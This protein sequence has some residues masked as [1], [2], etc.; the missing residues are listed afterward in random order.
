ML[1]ED[2]T[3]FSQAILEE[4]KQEA[5]EIV[6]R[7]RR[8]AER[9]F[10]GAR[11]ELDQIYLA[12][13][14]HAKKQQAQTRYN[15]IISAAELEV[16]RQKL[17]AQERLIA[18]VQEQVKER[19]LQARNDPRYPDILVSLIRRGIAELEGETFEIIVAPEDS[20]LVTDMMLGELCEE[21]GKIITLSKQSQTEITGA[22]IQRADKRVMCDN[23]FQA[24]LQRQQNELRL[25]IAEGLFG[26]VE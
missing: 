24:I 3:D 12:E 20:H 17:L 7:A 2:D 8:E 23:S 14:P 13:S 10:D 21:T 18:E 22:I 5:E 25:L 16:R 11:A 9:I 1:V 26:E 6:D 15:Q 19:L 4:T